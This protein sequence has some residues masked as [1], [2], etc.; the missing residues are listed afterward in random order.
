MFAFYRKSSVFMERSITLPVFVEC[1]LSLLGFLLLVSLFF[2]PGK[3][4]R[5]AMVIGGGEVA[6]EVLP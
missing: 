6:I 5:Q 2:H 3:A 4:E 1:S